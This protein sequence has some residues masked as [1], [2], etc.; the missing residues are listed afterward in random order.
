MNWKSILLTV[1][2]G[3]LVPMVLE[4]RTWRVEQDGTGD[5]LTLQSAVDAAASGDTILIGPGRYDQLH[6]SPYGETS[7][8]YWSLLKGIIFIGTHV[9]SVIVGP[10]AYIDDTNGFKCESISSQEFI[11][12]TFNNL[13]RGLGT[14]GNLK[15]KGC[16]FIECGYGVIGYGVPG[17]S[18]VT[19]TACFFQGRDWKNTSHA[20][21][22]RDYAS[23]LLDNCEIRDMGMYFQGISSSNVTDCK[24]ESTFYKESTNFYNSNVFFA[25]NEVEARLGVQGTSWVEI[26]NNHFFFSQDVSNLSIT[27]RTASVEAYDNIFEG[28]PDATITMLYCS[29]ITGSGNHILNGGSQYSIYLFEG[30]VQHM[31]TINLSNNYWGTTD[32]TAIADWIL[33]K[34][35][36]SSMINEV[37][38]L[39]FSA[40]PLPVEGLKKS[41]GGMKAMF[42]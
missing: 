19:V 11:D 9:D 1:V 32:S 30:G 18:E 37:Q 13:K 41:F 40:D 38:F 8:V 28:G 21:N 17:V 5:W 25:Y 22:I 10:L 35:D 29:S 14:N 15:V 3:L 42:R 7:V 34:N 12:I 23:A 36:D 6:S 39:P 26:R 27:D 16:K 2:I 31:A 24:L 20:L 33:D 4:G